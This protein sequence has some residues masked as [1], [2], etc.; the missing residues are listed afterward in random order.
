MIK[1]VAML[2]LILSLIAPHAV[3]GHGGMHSSGHDGAA[4][5]VDGATFD[6]QHHHGDTE[7]CCDAVIGGCYVAD[8]G[9]GSVSPASPPP[10]RTII[11]VIHDSV[12]DGVTPGFD[13]PPP[14]V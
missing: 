14:R 13:P 9:D 2:S 6:Q 5:H 8:L 11:A 1:F 7:H 4:D 3:S 10:A 12:S